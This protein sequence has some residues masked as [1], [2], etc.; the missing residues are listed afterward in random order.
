MLMAMVTSILSIGMVSSV[1]LVST[2]HEVFAQGKTDTNVGTV[3]GNGNNNMSRMMNSMQNRSGMNSG[4]MNANMTMDQ[5]LDMMDMMHNM[6]MNMMRMMAHGG[7]MKADNMT[8]TS[9]MTTMR[10]M[11]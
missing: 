11:Q 4:S 2:I 7:A 6:M 10:G 9:N 8:G 1:P 3:N 5:M